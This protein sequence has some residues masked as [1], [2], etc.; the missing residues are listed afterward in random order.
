M[1]FSLNADHRSI[2]RRGNQVESTNPIGRGVSQCDLRIFLTYDFMLSGYFDDYTRELM[3]ND[4]F[5]YHLVIIY[6]IMCMTNIIN[7]TPAV[8]MKMFEVESPWLI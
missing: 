5:A 7:D 6:Y 4:Y 1:V 2:D 3:L 8:K